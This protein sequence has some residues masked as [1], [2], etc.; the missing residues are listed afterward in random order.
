VANQVTCECGYVMRDDDEDRVVALVREHIRTDHPAL[1]EM[2]T[3]EM[4]RTWIE[5]APYER[6]SALVPPQAGDQLR[7]ATLIATRITLLEPAGRAG[8]PGT[9]ASR[10]SH[11]PTDPE[12][13]AYVSCP[14]SDTRST[15]AF[16][17]VRS[18]GCCRLWGQNRG[19]IL[20]PGV[21][22][23][24]TRRSGRL[25]D[26]KTAEPWLHQPCRRRAHVARRLEPLR[27]PERASM[28]APQ[29]KST[30]DTH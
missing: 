30:H 23:A 26:I 28:L 22:P 3:P 8:A 7:D 4:I 21:S 19:V 13:C 17:Q 24:A 16:L 6:S 5:I 9:R 18:P 2:A 15:P 12:A 27:S 29:P 11:R 1:L 10:S 14:P 20:Q 25:T